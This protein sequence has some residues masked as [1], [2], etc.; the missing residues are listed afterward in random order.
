MRNIVRKDD[1]TLRTFR[2]AKAYF[3]QGRQK[4]QTNY[5][6][7]SMNDFLQEYVIN[8]KNIEP[9]ITINSENKVNVEV[10][11]SKIF[12]LLNRV[13]DYAN[14]YVSEIKFLENNE[15]L[16]EFAHSFWHL[17]LK[18]FNNCNKA[19]Y[20][21]ENLER[22]EATHFY[23]KASLLIENIL[24]YLVLVDGLL[25]VRNQN[26]NLTQPIDKLKISEITDAIHQ[27]DLKREQVD[28]F[29]TDSG[30]QAITT[31]LLVMSGL[32]HGEL[33][34]GKKTDHDVFLFDES[35]FE[36]K[37]FMED[38]DSSLICKTKSLAKILFIDFT[39]VNK[40]VFDEFKSLKSIVI[41][42]TH[43]PSL[44]D[45]L[46]KK[47][48]TEAHKRDVWVALVESDLKHKQLGLDKYQTGKIMTLA[49]QNKVLSSAARDEFQ[50]ISDCAM[51]SVTASYLNMVNE[52]CQE[53]ER[54]QKVQTSDVVSINALSKVGVFAS[55][56]PIIQ[57]NIS[58]SED[59]QK[60][61]I[62]QRNC[63][64]SNSNQLS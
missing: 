9:E 30:Q 55:R 54:I 40:L 56:Q 42:L 38:V 51:H 52:I 23:A 3:D 53:K 34:D 60:I 50:S 14:H 36:V 45:D 46:L 35:Y 29:F 59:M 5:L 47:I 61:S 24:E 33:A 7:Q 15:P 22:L 41:D 58:S 48:I 49:P 28:V 26:N 12:D 16:N 1:R 4:S 44:D 2:Q 6:K 11:S 13:V 18:L 37:S 63:T 27:L 19:K 64:M 21:I 8:Q 31:S 25:L 43:F 32:L 39:Q 20:L 57:P 10:C 17:I 62:A